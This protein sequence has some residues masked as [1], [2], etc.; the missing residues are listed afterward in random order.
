M[1]FNQR[2]DIFSLSGCSLKQ[3][4]KFTYLGSSAL[5]TKTG[6]NT[7]LAKVLT[8]NDMLLVI[9][10]SDLT[11][12][13]K[14]IFFQTKLVPILRYGS[15]T[16][17]QT[18]RIK[19]KLDG[20]YTRIMWAILNKTWTQH[21]TKQLQYGHLPPITKSIQVRWTRSAGHCWRS[22]DEL[23]SDILLCT[24]SHGRA[25]TGR[26]AR[27]YIQQLCANTGYSLEGQPG[28]IDDRDSWREK[29]KEVR[30]VGGLW[31]W[32]YLKAWTFYVAYK[33]VKPNNKNNQRKCFITTIEIIRKVN[34]YMHSIWKVFQSKK[35]GRGSAT[36][37]YMVT[38]VSGARKVQN[39][40]SSEIWIIPIT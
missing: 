3:M 1:C 4:D 39:I 14:R 8:A 30:A 36:F 11:D 33:S 5:S 20:N 34:Y 32:K 40:F 37:W 21:L 19:K 28:A 35:L 38:T 22:K 13:I 2:G 24:P 15:T 7:R 16:R 31:W 27:T 25:K 6:I 9:W 29:V 12:K 23:I 26:P 10:K 18:K 17:T